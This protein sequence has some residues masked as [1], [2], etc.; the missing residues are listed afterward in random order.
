LN[1]D[2]HHVLYYIPIGYCMYKI[3]TNY[4]VGLDSLAWNVRTVPLLQVLIDHD[5][6]ETQG[7]GS[8]EREKRKQT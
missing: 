5:V 3:V 7:R 8:K 1:I 4:Y 6:L 2:I